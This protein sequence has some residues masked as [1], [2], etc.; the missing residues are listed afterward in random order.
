MKPTQ[1]VAVTV[2]GSL[3][4]SL[5]AMA[6]RRKRQRVADVDARPAAGEDDEREP[7]DGPEA[8]KVLAI[9]LDE[10]V[11]VAVRLSPELSRSKDD[12]LAAK[13]QAQAARRDQQ[14]VVSAGAQ[15]ERFATDP[16]TSD[17]G[18]F[19]LAN[20]NKI[21][22]NLGIGRNLPTGG[23]IGLEFGILRTLR[24][25]ELPNGLE[26]EQAAQQSENGIIEDEYTLHQA[27]AKL[28]FKQPLARG[29][30]SDVALAAQKKGDLAA[31]E[32]T[33]KTQLAAEELLRDIVSG[34]WELSYAAY[35]VDTRH[36][37]L[38]LARKQE[39]LTR[40]GMRAGTIP[41][42][43]LNAVLYELSV[44]EEALLDSK[45]QYEKKSLELR[46]RVGLELGRR[47]I[48]MRPLD[49]FEVQDDEF[50]VEDVLKRTRKANRRV[51]SIILAK[52]QAEIDVKVAKNGMLPQVDLTLS[53]AMFGTGQVADQAFSGITDGGNFQVVAGLTVS[54]EVGGAAKGAHDAAIARR[55]RLEI[56]QADAARTVE[57]EVVHAV[58]Q[59]SS[60][61]AR[62]ALAEKAVQVAEENV[63]AERALFQ[64]N[65]STN[66]NVMQRQTELVTARLR[67][68]R[69]IAD[70]HTAVAQVQF[71]GGMLLEQYGVDV[72]PLAR[73]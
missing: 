49:A 12:R 55:H 32:A 34:Y 47:D 27:T 26:L 73:K 68:G 61:R 60:A 43:Q 28:T 40:L 6:D 62:V 2:L 35:E 63:K 51:A 1:L 58:H 57:T 42:T 54:F 24:E 53:G 71:L 66:F 14:W 65:R 56:D 64:G 38:E 21:T 11:D 20:E 59:V 19:N 44:R 67:R 69:A 15:F 25:I 48:V 9:K 5:P 50:D 31:T 72:R 16:V 30:G 10:L 37:A 46:R 70:Y 45:I 23:N 41:E 39:E 3:V 13:G 52:R 7:Q 18:P 17:V 22:A 33:I 8:R 29:F 4:T 36:D